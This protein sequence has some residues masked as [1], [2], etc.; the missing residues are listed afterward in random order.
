MYDSLVPR[1]SPSLE[2]FNLTFEPLEEKRREKMYNLGRKS[3]LVQFLENT[4]I[5]KE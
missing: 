2:I 5:E 4:P 1:P 3:N